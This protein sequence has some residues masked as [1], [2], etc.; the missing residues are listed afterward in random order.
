MG[1]VALMKEGEI[2][3][4]KQVGFISENLQQK[5]NKAT[6]YHIGS[7]TKTF[8]SV[9]VLRATE[10][11]KLSLNTTLDKFFPKLEN[12]SI[13]TV[14]NLLNH[15]S[16]IRNFTKDQKNSVLFYQEN[17]K[18]ELIKLISNYQSDFTPNSKF[19]YCNSNYLLLTYILESIY[20]TSYSSLLNEKVITPLKLK[21]THFSKGIESSKNQAKSFFLSNEWQIFPETHY[22][23][24]SGAG[25]IAST[26]TDLLKFHKALFTHEIL[27][28]ENVDRMLTLK[29]KYGLGMFAI[30]YEKQFG[31]G[32]NRKIDGFKSILVT[33]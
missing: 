3:Y 1:S 30:P 17:A 32:H 15:R 20:K 4:T 6:S 21:Q 22:S 18:S 29:D 7:I 2:V 27:S 11:G 14:E 23:V 9:L 16:G 31:F 24:S 28:K 12:A 19:E 10:E 5:P 13:I 33:F 8:T 25:A 26:P